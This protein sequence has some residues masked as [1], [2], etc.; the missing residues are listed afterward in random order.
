MRHVTAPSS[1][2]ER[3]DPKS[4]FNESIKDLQVGPVPD[5]L[6]KLGLKHESGSF[7]GN[8]SKPDDSVFLIYYKRAKA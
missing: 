4:R 3:E 8:K 1:K 2:E 7:L 5:D 6:A